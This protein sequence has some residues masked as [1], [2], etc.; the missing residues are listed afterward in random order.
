MIHTDCRHYRNS[1]PCAP[2]KRTHVRCERC[3]D[4][5]PIE[6]RILIVKLGAMGDVL[7]TTS[8]L[9][10]LKAQ[11]PRSH[12][13]WITRANAAP[14]LD[15]NPS[16]DRVLTVE[17]R[18]LEF[19][20]AEDFDLALGPDADLLSGSIM[21]LASAETKRGFVANR[22]G[23]I[24]PLNDAA[25]AWWH[26]GLDDG[27]KRANRRS[28]GEWLY[29]VC[30]L[31]PPV[32]RPWLRPSADARGRAERFV[33]ERAPLAARRVCLNTGA[34]SRWTEKRWKVQHYV[35]LAR[36]IR[37]HDPA[38]A[39][40]VVGGPAETE[41][42]AALLAA[43]PDLVDAGTANSIEAFAALVASCDWIVTPDSLGYHV[44]CAV[45]TPAICVV[46]PTSPWELDLYG[47][48]Q[49]LHADMD[50]IACYLAE[51]PFATTCM[52]ALTARAVWAHANAAGAG[53]MALTR[54]DAPSPT[55][56][57]RA[58]GSSGAMVT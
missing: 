51:C 41:F 20:H 55:I 32:A 4:Y 23:G 3:A 15:G 19:L 8:C 53:V 42:N 21:Q 27:A 35:E 25:A 43:A 5:A 31:P 38:Q 52:D 45:G 54:D 9:P 29:D 6:Q 46:G 48:N 40:I 34:S 49:V 10:P 47:V 1:L 28:Y 12:V 7:R 22:R 13:T 56:P 50:C 37:T 2:H 36:L 14:L 44:A 16:I 57:L 11:Y 30:E 26:L 18:Y 24:M 39:V 17:S 58:G 33:R